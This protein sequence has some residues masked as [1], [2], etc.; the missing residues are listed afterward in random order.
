M[1][2][3]LIHCLLWNYESPP[4]AIDDLNKAMVSLPYEDGYQ[5]NGLWKKDYYD[6]YT[7]KQKQ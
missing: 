6:K 1:N 7:F 5:F 3:I 4:L 2:Q